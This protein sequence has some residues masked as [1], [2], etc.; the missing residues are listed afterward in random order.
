MKLS[1]PARIYDALVEH[2]RRGLPNEACAFLGGRDY[3]AEKFYPLRN[4]AAS[5]L[6]YRPADS[7]MLQAM[8]DIDDLGMDL[9]AICH[10]HVAGPPYPSTTDVRE[11]YY[12]DSVYVIVSLADRA[13]PETKGWLVRKADWRDET[14]ELD[15]VELVIS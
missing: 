11:A 10:S 6:Y 2:C 12:P 7:E 15:E 9:V 13:G 14:G 5:P 4:A 8:R 3:A 1:I